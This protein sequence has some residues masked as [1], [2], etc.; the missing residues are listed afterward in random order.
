MTAFTYRQGDLA[1]EQVPLREIVGQ[2]GSPVYVYSLDEIE[3]RYG[4]YAAAFPDALICYAYKANSSLALC[5]WLRT[6]GAGADVVSG[7]ELRVA[8]AAGVPGGLTVFNGNGKSDAEIAA[9]IEGGVLSINADAVEELPRLA[10]VAERLGRRAPVTIRINPGVDPHTHRHIA[11]GVTSS[12]FGVALAQAEAAYAHLAE[13]PGLDPVGVHSHIGSQ[14]TELGPFVETVDRLADLA[15]RLMRQ[16]FPLRLL[17]IGGGLGIDYHRWENTDPPTTQPLTPTDLAG[18]LLPRVADLGLRLALEPG[19]SLVAPAGVLVGQVLHLKHGADTTRVVLDT[20]M[21]ALIR[22][23][24]Y[25]AYHA[26]SPLKAGTPSLTADVVGPNCESSD[27]IGRGRRLPALR[28]GD[29]LAV[30]DAGAYGYPLA[31]NYNSR[32]RPAEVVVR[33]DRWWTVRPAETWE[34]LLQGQ[35]GVMEGMG[36]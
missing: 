13:F 35:V 2:L 34:G 9:A 8:Q 36:N 33:G 10:A 3:R 30:M 1:C 31:S 11:T 6:L 12:Q 14:I 15:R 17:D 24:L 5:T 18:A 23:S 27:V 25:E 21:N 22:P 32:P 26:V 20:G 28:S 7:G 29:Y 16:G 4:A 19:R